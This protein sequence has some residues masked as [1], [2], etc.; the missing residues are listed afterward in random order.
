MTTSEYR[1]KVLE[2]YPL[3]IIGKNC[4]GGNPVLFQITWL[5]YGM[6]LGW[7]KRKAWIDAYEKNVLK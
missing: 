3:A 5:D 7:S 6:G 1:K 4:L 2:K